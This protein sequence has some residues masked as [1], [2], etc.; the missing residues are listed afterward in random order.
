MFDSKDLHNEIVNNEF[1]LIDQTEMN[2]KY[3]TQWEELKNEMHYTFMTQLLPMRLYNKFNPMLQG[4]INYIE[5][6]GMSVTVSLN[7]NSA[8]F[9]SS[10]IGIKEICIT[11]EDVV[12]QKLLVVK[13]VHEL[14][15]FI[16]YR[17]NYKFNYDKFRDTK[18]TEKGMIETEI[19]A[20]VYAKMLMKVFNKLYPEYEIENGYFEEIKSN[21]LLTYVCEQ[22]VLDKLLEVESKIFYNYVQKLKEDVCD[23]THC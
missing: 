21:A 20:W 13:L 11:P 10:N 14:G 15:H 1:G 7:S 9:V 4:I 8:M 23:E 17:Q 18:E 2:F 5:S 22:Y 16:D 12:D 19:V 3:T 6:K